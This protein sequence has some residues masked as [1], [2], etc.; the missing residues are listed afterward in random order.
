MR[1]D[2]EGPAVALD[3]TQLRGDGAK[4]ALLL[5][6]D[7]GHVKPR[8]RFALEMPSEAFHV[9]LQLAEP[10]VM[11]LVVG[12]LQ[13]RLLC[14]DVDLVDRPGRSDA[15]FA[16]SPSSYSF[17]CCLVHSYPFHGWSRVV[18]TGYLY[19]HVKNLISTPYMPK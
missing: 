18:R 16:P 17:L 5:P 4:G 3:I 2:T 12:P 7:L 10:I 11:A 14:G 8:I 19:K 1:F 15:Q 9:P 6:T 13:R